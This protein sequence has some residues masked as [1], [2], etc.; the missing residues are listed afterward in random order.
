MGIA[1][2]QGRVYLELARALQPHWRGD[3]AL[4]A[5]LQRLLA[6][7]PGCGSR[8]RRLYRELI[9]TT[10]RHLPWIEPCLGADPDEALRRVAW[11]A[12]ATPA[13]TGFRA[14]WATGEPP[15]GDPAE[16]LPAWFRPEAPMLFTP[17]EAAAQVRRAPLWLRL[18]T[19]DPA[20]VH[21]EF[22]RRGWKFSPS[23]VLPDALRLE[24]EA[25][26]TTTEALR[27][28]SVEVQDLGSQLL[29]ASVGILP[30]GHWLDACAGAGGKSLQ[31]ARLLGPAGAVEA[32]DIRPAALAELRERATRAGLGN[33]R[34]TARPARAAYDGVLV[35][36]P[37]SGTGTWRRA[38][39]L[40]WVT[41]PEHLARA[42]A[43]QLE[44]LRQLAPLVRPGGLLV[45]ATCSL[46]RSE[47]AAVIAGFLRENPAFA[48]QPPAADFG[49]TPAE[50]CLTVWPS[51]H[52]TDGFFVAAL[53]RV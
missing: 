5:R 39:H 16:L 19:P 15:A 35:D 31:L 33:L 23:S 32:T 52:D 44:L 2:S 7:R 38:P 43:R 3:F 48:P 29:L 37:C 6:A 9:Y 1:A 10:L 47:N 4:P 8:D 49:F 21:A 14:A 42:A 40:K 18:Q 24:T 30:G 53:R 17:E 34:V 41:R 45:Y 27:G 28:G 50:G 25:D 13:T 51:R 20:T 11:L 46:A 26:L 22:S 12:A 36:A